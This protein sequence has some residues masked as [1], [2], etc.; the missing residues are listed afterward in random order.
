MAVGVVLVRLR[1][2]ALIFRWLCSGVTHPRPSREGRLGC[3]FLLESVEFEWGGFPSREG[4]LGTYFFLK[5]SKLYKGCCF[6]SPVQEKYLVY[7][8]F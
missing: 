6:L 2:T 3:G 7:V 8:F 4:S 5:V 1:V